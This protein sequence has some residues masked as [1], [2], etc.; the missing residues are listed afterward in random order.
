MVTFHAQQFLVKVRK[1]E[2]RTVT[3]LLYQYTFETGVATHAVGAHKAPSPSPATWLDIPLISQLRH[4]AEI[5]GMTQ[6]AY[7]YGPFHILERI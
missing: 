3:K 7:Y 5:G 4:M 2:V 1:E 6:M